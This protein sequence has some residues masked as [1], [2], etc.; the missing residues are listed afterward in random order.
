M[1]SSVGGGLSNERIIST[2]GPPP[3]AFRGLSED[4]FNPRRQPGGDATLLFL[5]CMLS[6]LL[7]TVLKIEV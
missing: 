2:N 7:A 4:R 1:T 5:G 3:E 6:W